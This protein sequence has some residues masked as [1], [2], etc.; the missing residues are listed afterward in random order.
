TLT[1][2]RT[3]AVALAATLAI[4]I[5]TAFAAA[6]AAVLA[7][8]IA[9][10]FGVEARWIGAFI[11]LVYAGGMFASLASGGFIERHGSIR[12]S[13][14]CVVLCA[15]CGAGI[16]RARAHSIALRAAAAVV[17]VSGYGPITPASSQLLQRT[18]PPARMA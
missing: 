17:I 7:P 4:Q 3:A 1:S 14:A 5:Y 9:H 2:T 8:E 15:I 12:V 10:A 6:A 16:A 18:A 13:Q 11:G